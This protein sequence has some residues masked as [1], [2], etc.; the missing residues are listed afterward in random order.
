V[1]HYAFEHIGNNLNQLVAM[2]HALGWAQ[3][4]RIDEISEALSQMIMQVTDRI[5]V[6]EK[7][8]IKEVLKRGKQM[9]E[10]DKFWEG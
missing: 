4:D 1:R 10:Q 7:Q 9:A 6:P 5:I 3:R 8:N 2:A